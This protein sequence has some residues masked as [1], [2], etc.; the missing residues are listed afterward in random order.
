[1]IQVVFDILRYIK[2][3]KM[4]DSLLDL[5]FFTLGDYA[6]TLASFLLVSYDS[7][8]SQT[9]EYDFNIYHSSAKNTVECAFGEINLRWGIFGSVW[10]A[11]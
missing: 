1:M 8:A 3:Y 4:K 5:G 10:N 9:L 7:P 11:V 6:Y 2:L